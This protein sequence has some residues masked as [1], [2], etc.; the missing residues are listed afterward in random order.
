[1][2]SQSFDPSC[3]LIASM[4]IAV[5]LLIVILFIWSYKLLFNKSK[6]KTIKYPKPIVSFELVWFDQISYLLL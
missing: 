2:R 1:M 3:E 5:I 6:V 4:M